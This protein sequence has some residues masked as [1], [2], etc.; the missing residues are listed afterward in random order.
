MM[1]IHGPSIVKDFLLRWVEM[2]MGS[3]VGFGQIMG[4]GSISPDRAIRY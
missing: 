4:A 1:V 2:L 3:M